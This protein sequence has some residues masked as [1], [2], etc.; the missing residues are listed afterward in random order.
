MQPTTKRCVED[1]KTLPWKK[2]QKI[3]FRLQY[4]IYKAQQKG[5]YKLINQLQRALFSSRAA[6]FLAI[7]QVT[8]LN[9]GKR[10]ATVYK[11]SKL[12]SKQRF[13]LFDE[14]KSLNNY[15]H[16]ELIRLYISNTYGEKRILCIPSIKDRCVH[17]LVK[18]L[19]EPV[20]EAY[21]SIGNFG[22]R[23]GRSYHDV[24]QNIFTNLKRNA[25]GYTKSILQLNISKCFDKIDHKKLMSL[26]H[27][28]KIIKNIIKLVLKAGTLKE[29]QHFLEAE[30]ISQSGLLSPLL[31]NIALH[32]IEDLWNEPELHKKTLQ[33]GI[34]YVDDMLFFIKPKEN[35]EILR[36][37]I[38]Q[39][40]TDRGLSIK[41]AE[42]KI[43]KAIDG[44]DFLGWR[45]EIKSNNIL[46]CYPSKGN[47]TE[48]IKKIKKTMTNSKFSL[49]ER[50][51]MVKVIYNEWRNYH[52]YCDLS[53]INLWS[54]NNWVYKYSKKL[55]S[56][57][58]RE[59]R[60]QAKE[61]RIQ[62]IKDIFNGHKNSLF[63]F[64][65]IKTHKS[66]FCDDWVQLLKC[67]L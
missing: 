31:C 47:R 41:E 9:I 17:C 2:F 43:V 24:L 40:L 26:I 10:T 1:W 51:K 33:R 38:D 25:N 49:H 22:F 39:F 44:F 65:S 54:I 27:V 66:F 5:N 19:L 14:I 52:Q 42:F 23:P 7:R 45:F 32:G 21:A 67:K 29:R 3:V 12:N 58:K 4:R 53:K 61:Y 35:T 6:K 57:L 13:E 16:N 28:P 50:L 18:Y 62:F 37:K 59:K 48:L 56:K 20:Y 63:R 11:I 8:Q 64:K 34:R 55:N 30:A 15:K 36:R 60:K 46:T